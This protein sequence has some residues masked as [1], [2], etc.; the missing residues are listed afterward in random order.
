MPV[1]ER[2]QSVT[3]VIRSRPQESAGSEALTVSDVDPTEV[4]VRARALRA[5]EFEAGPDE[6]S[7]APPT[8][9][10]GEKPEKVEREGLPPGYRMRADAHYVENLTSRRGERTAADP[11]AADMTD[12]SD[13]LLAQLA[14]D[15]ATIESAA[16]ALAGDGGRM[17]KRV[18]IDLIKSQAWRAAWAVRAH[19]LVG[20][21]HRVQV[22][23]RPL[24]FLLGQIRSGWAAECRLAGLTLHVEASDWNSVVSV[25]EASVIAG[26]SGAIVATL[27]LIG[28]TDS[29]TLTL[30]AVAAGGV[31]RSIDLTQDEVLVTPGEGGRFFDPSWAD[32]PGGWIA[33][34]GAAVAR[35]AAQQ[36][37]GD[38]VF[39]AD[40][41]H[42][43]TVR[44]QFSRG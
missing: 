20:G 11:R 39:L 2:V 7:P 4:S 3:I 12:R 6:V 14:E 29:A 16:Q 42:G 41:E 36:H 43:S 10:K 30:A 31:L 26:V 15:L 19:G 5:E 13:R 27:G 33:G 38:A 21:R 24:G 17:A 34:L 28:Q 23:P 35:V 32:R 25:D 22:R 44:M 40:E 8:P 37:G 1:R 18:S 9:R